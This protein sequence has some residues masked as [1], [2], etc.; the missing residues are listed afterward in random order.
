MTNPDSLR[1]SLRLLLNDYGMLLVLFVIAVV[2]SVVTWSEQ[3]PTGLAAARQLA[4]SVSQKFGPGARVLVVAREGDEDK[5]FA[6]ELKTQLEGEGARVAAVVNGAPADARRAL[7]AAAGEGLDAV[8]CHPATANWGVLESMANISPAY[9][10]TVILKPESYYWPN[11]LKADNLLNVAS[12]IAVIAI[13]AIGMTMV[14]ISGGI[15]L[16]VG[17]LIAL[18]AVVAARLIR[19]YGGGTSAGT[20][21]ILVA[22]GLAIGLCAACG[23]FSALMVTTFRVPPFI[24]TLSMMLMASGMAYRIAEG[25]SNNQV[26]SQFKWLGRE[27][28]IVPNSVVLMIGLYILAHVVMTRTAFGR[29]I[30]AVGGNAEA[31]RLSGVPVKRI[32]LAVYTICGALAGLGGI[33]MASQLQSGAPTYGI[34]YELKV[35]AAV[36]VGGASLSGGEGRVFG[37][38]IGAFIIAIIHNGMNLTGVGSDT[39]K[40][41]LGAV[42]LGGVIFDKLKSSGDRT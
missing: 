41:V 37:T 17:S 27:G 16:S 6:E 3:H 7:V 4:G 19:D 15:D 12:Q 1:R 5:A 28:T 2:L 31:A 30:Y 40:I 39:Q 9:E 18:A 20:P 11:F 10:K 35:I 36:V 13:L 34:E 25:E 33:L 42:I 38:L 22:C 8:A 32:L 26:P 21:A 24:V 29:Y 23:A 14:V